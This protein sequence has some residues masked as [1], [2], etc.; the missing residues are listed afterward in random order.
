M[1]IKYL[2][3]NAIDIFESCEM[4]RLLLHVVN[5]Q[6]VMGS[7]IAKEIKERIPDAFSVYSATHDSGELKL[8]SISTSSGVVNMAAQINYGRGHRQLNYGA[9]ASCLHQV[10]ERI[11]WTKEY[12][13]A[14]K[15]FVP[16]L[17]GCDR[18]GG[19]WEVVSEMLDFYFEDV[20]I[21]RL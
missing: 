18:A 15:V 6:G 8:G 12:M 1:S 2:D 13:D 16:Y 10:S 4:P 3:G 11:S 19:D 7:G 21:C 9:L 17:I 5:C 20:I 14:T